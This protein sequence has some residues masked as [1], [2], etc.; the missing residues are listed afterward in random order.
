MFS[1]LKPKHSHSKLITAY[2]VTTTLL[3]V[4]LLILLYT[5]ATSNCFFPLKVIL[6][7]L[8][9]AGIVGFLNYFF[10][11]RPILRVD[12]A[13]VSIL[14]SKQFDVTPSL[15]E[16][17]QDL[18]KMFQLILDREYS[19]EILRKQAELDALQS[20]INP[21]FL[22]NALETLRSQAVLQDAPQIAEM[23]YA[24]SEFFRYSISRKAKLVPLEEELHS[25]AVYTKIQNFRFGDRYVIS[26]E[27][28]D[29]EQTSKLLIPKLTLQPIIEN[30]ILH[31]LRDSLNGVDTVQIIAYKTEYHLILQVIDHGAGIAEDS[32]HE[33]NKRLY[34]TADSPDVTLSAPKHNGIALENINDRIKILCGEDYGLTITSAVGF[35]TT[36]SVT[37]PVLSDRQEA[38]ELQASR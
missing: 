1:F 5:R 25:V 4:P 8:I 33:I 18:L 34:H 28:D 37:L 17:D 12:R 7:Y 38:I 35:G 3:A 6:L 21:H 29:P 15:Q 36:V 13:V 11:L 31:G 22:Y 2:I 30:S 32:L 9:W 26:Y 20:Q 27:V 23:S 16:S 14:L 19:S 10:L 24:L